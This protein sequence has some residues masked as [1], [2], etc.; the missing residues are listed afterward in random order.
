MARTRLRPTTEAARLNPD[1]ALRTRLAPPIPRRRVDF[2]APPLQKRSVEDTGV[3]GAMKKIYENA[4]AAL[5]GLLKDGMSIAAGGFGLSGI[6]E[7]LIA[8]IHKSGV[9][10]LTI[11]FDAPAFRADT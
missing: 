4:D 6:P 3:G 7:L 5:D 1:A 11:L 2:S 8:A 10:E 9:K